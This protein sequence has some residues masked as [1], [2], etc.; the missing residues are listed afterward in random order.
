MSPERFDEQPIQVRPKERCITR[1][2]Q[3]ALPSGD[4]ETASHPFDRANGAT[5]VD[6]EFRP[7]QDWPEEIRVSRF[8]DRHDDFS[9]QGG[10]RVGNSCDHRFPGD[11]DEGFRGTES[12]GLAAREDECGV[13]GAG[14]APALEKGLRV[15]SRCA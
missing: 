10:D 2:H 15:V 4:L 6:R 14:I 8:R 13:H 7:R 5:A 12:D 9:D 3:D 11:I 1:G